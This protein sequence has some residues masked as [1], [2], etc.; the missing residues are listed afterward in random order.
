MNE[1]NLHSNKKNQIS[2]MLKKMKEKRN[3]NKKR[4]K[5]NNKKT[6]KKKNE[7]CVETKKAPLKINTV[8]K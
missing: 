3:K 5:N 7:I 6:M 1:S 4:K 2:P 8:H